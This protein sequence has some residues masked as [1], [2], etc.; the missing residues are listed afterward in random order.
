[1]QIEHKRDR[2]FMDFLRAHLPSTLESPATKPTFAA[3]VKVDIVD[4]QTL[5]TP[6][7]PAPS[8]NVASKTI[9]DF[10]QV[11]QLLDEN[12]Y[13]QIRLKQEEEEHV[14][15]L[16]SPRFQHYGYDGNT[17]VSDEGV[18]DTEGK[19]VKC[20]R[21]FA[22][23]EKVGDYEGELVY[24]IPDHLDHSRPKKYLITTV[25]QPA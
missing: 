11:L 18:V 8:S 22:K 1:M 2:H 24:R 16:K 14:D 17:Y 21:H 19:G 7:S 20:A 4:N 25:A 12:R 13:D 5:S 10:E 15:S 23:G 3:N 9:S 6:L